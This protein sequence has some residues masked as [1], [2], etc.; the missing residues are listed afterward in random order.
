[1]SMNVTFN[2]GTNI[3]VATLDVQNRVSIATPLLP[4][5]ASRLGLNRTR[6]ESQHADDGGGICAE[7]DT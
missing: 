5:V 3:D 1:M 4:A 2:I 6:F 7:R